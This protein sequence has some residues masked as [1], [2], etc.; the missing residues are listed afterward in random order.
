MVLGCQVGGEQVEGNPHLVLFYPGLFR[1]LTDEGRQGFINRYGT[2]F[3]SESLRE[4]FI[5]S[6]E[7]STQSDTELF[8]PTPLFGGSS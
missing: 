2:R 1:G 8:R 4:T 5:E 6:G 7:L 3:L